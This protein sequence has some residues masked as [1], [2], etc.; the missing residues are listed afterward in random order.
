MLPS[1]EFPKESRI[2]FK[3]FFSQKYGHIALPS[4]VE[5]FQTAVQWHSYSPRR[6]SF[7]PF[8]V[9]EASASEN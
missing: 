1:T 6:N 4:T 9:D 5:Y 8:V 3:I 2:N 7:N